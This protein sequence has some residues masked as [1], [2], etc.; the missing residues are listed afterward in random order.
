MWVKC[1][2]TRTD[3]ASQRNPSIGALADMPRGWT[4][5]RLAQSYLVIAASLRVIRPAP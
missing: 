5:W 1:G 3:S 2:S 4:A